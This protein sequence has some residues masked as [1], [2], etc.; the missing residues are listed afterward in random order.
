MGENSQVCQHKSAVPGLW[1]QRQQDAWN[2]LTSQPSLLGELQASEKFCIKNKVDSIRRG[3]AAYVL[4][5]LQTWLHCC[6][7]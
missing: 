2:S 1:R 5:S 4:C 3:A 7:H 6:E